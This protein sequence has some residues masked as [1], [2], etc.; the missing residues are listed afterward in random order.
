MLDWRESGGPPVAR[1]ERKGFGIRLVQGV[2]SHELGG[3]ATI[4]FHTEGVHCEIVVPS[5]HVEDGGADA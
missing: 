2:V 4:D 1:P 5:E 3:T